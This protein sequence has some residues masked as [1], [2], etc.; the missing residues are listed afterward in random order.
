M[1]EN[2]N[3][4]INNKIDSANYPLI[5]VNF[6]S[7]QNTNNTKQHDT[8]P[9]EMI[10]ECEKGSTICYSISYIFV[11]LIFLVILIN[12][13]ISEI[14]YIP[15][16]IVSI[17][18]LIFITLF[19][20][21]LY[22]NT[23]HIKLIK[24]KSLNLL[25]VKKI[26]YLNCAK[27]IF[28]FNSKNVILDIIKYQ[29]SDEDSVYE[30]EALLITKLLKDSQIDLNSSNIKNTPIKNL[31][32]VFTGIKKKVYTS[33]SLRN[34]LGINPEIEN[35]VYFNIYKYMGISGNNPIFSDYQLSR[36]MKM[37]DYFFTYFLKKPCCYCGVITPII[38]ALITLFYISVPVIILLESD[39]VDILAS[40]IMLIVMFTI[41]SIVIIFNILAI[42]KYFLRID[43]I[44]SNDF[45]TIFIALL[46]HNGTSYKK[47][48]IN[49]FNLIE[50]FI[51]ENYEG[52]YNK[53]ILKV[54]YKDKTVEDIFRIDESKYC[55]DG[56]LFLLNE[57]IVDINKYN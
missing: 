38:I 34:F 32:H 17:I 29:T 46:N 4:M 9:K 20:L 48:F 19:F 42:I 44:F 41:P 50:R 45:D 37:S 54:L 51:L 6:Q 28:Y 26:N 14:S 10:I 2:F 12:L 5:P 30:H 21:F 18:L 49:S 24:N 35:P 25:T 13:I 43:I 11:L 40:L 27:S 1:S 8:A 33:I 47:I 15:V 39:N 23:K 3:E 16:L 56:L 36:Y 57:K 55:L 7:A 22:L 52:S 53:S 31:Y